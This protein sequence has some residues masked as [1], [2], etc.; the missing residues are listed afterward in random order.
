MRN[1]EIIPFSSVGPVSF[2]MSR[3]QVR[4]AMGACTNSFF[5]TPTDTRP[6]DAWHNNSFQV[7]YN[8]ALGTV[9]FIELSSSAEFAATC[10]GVS[11]F[12]TPATSVIE[13]LERVAAVDTSDP[14]YGYSFVFPSLE[15]SFWRPI[16]EDPEG[17]YF[18]TVGLGQSGYFSNA[19]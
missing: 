1:Y 3:A 5:K 11:V 14:E 16:V 2:G 7:F 12:E 10:A 9:E 18:S 17:F 19:A 13:S 4:S 15:L 6:T 8:E